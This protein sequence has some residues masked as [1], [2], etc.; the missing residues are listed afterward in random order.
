M[1]GGKSSGVLLSP[2]WLH[3]AANF[4]NSNLI[5]RDLMYKKEYAAQR[6]VVKGVYQYLVAGFSEEEAIKYEEWFE[7]PYDIAAF[8]RWVGAEISNLIRQKWFEWIL[9]HDGEIERPEI[10]DIYSAIIAPKKY[11]LTPPLD[12]PELAIAREKKEHYEV[13]REYGCFRNQPAGPIPAV[14]KT[15]SELIRSGAVA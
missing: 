9:H 12:L 6:D 15:C 11:Q 5:W 14:S 8:E 1:T 7:H 3:T 4:T 13:M 10:D 2:V